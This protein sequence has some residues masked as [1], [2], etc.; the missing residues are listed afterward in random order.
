MT[1]IHCMASWLKPLKHQFLPAGRV[2]STWPAGPKITL[3]FPR[4]FVYIYFF[5]VCPHLSR[6]QQLHHVHCCHATL[7]CRLDDSRL[8]ESGNTKSEQLLVVHTGS[9]T[10]REWLPGELLSGSECRRPGWLNIRLVP[11]IFT[12]VQ[13]MCVII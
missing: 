9:L 5:F 13:C 1:L 6:A 12:P 2:Q 3:R 8:T 7:Q 10:N 11:L 4:L